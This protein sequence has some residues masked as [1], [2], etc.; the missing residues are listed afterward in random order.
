MRYG[1]SRGR[2]SPN[3]D[4]ERIVFH[5]A[6]EVPSV[7]GGCCAVLHLGQSRGESDARVD[8]VQSQLMFP[9]SFFAFLG[10][11]SAVRIYIKH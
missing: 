6:A 7:Y 3:R 11:Y 9:L 2:G 10:Y 4:G 5:G 8:A 1:C